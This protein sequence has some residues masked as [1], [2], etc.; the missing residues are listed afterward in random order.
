M[1]TLARICVQRP[2]FATVLSLTLLVVGAAGYVG[3]GVDRFP[4]VDFPF[5]VVSTTYPGASPAE[6]ETEVTDPI[7]EQVNT[8]GGIEALTSNSA[9][10]ISIVSVQFDLSKNV[11]VAAEEVRAKVALAKADLPP[12]VK[13]PVV[14]KIDIGATPVI[15]F[16]VSA[17]RPV[18][19][20]YEYVDKHVR[21]RIESVSG[22]GEVQIIGG[23]KRQ[24][25]VVVDPYRLRA[26]K[27]TVADITKALTT[28]NTMVPGG[29]VEQGDNELSLR[30][31]GRLP[32]VGQFNE[33][34]ISSL[35]NREIYLRDVAKTED[36]EARAVSLASIG[37]RDAVVLQVIKQTGANAVEVIDN[38]RDRMKLIEQALPRGYK[39]DVVRDQSTY[40]RA[41]LNA[42]REH[43]VMGAILAALVVLAFLGNLRSTIIAA[44]AIPTSV[45]TTFALMKY[46][47]FTQNNVTLLALTLSVG[48]VID[49]AIVVLENVYRVIEEHGLNPVEGAIRATKEIG[50]AVVAIT[51]SLVAVFLPVA[52]MS[53]IVG[54]FLNSFGITM[55]CAIGVSMFISFSLTPMLCSRWLQGGT[56]AKGHHEAESKSG[57]FRAVD[58]FYTRML[59]WSL[60]HRFLVVLGCVLLIFA[61]KFIGG[62]AKKSFLPDDDEAQFQVQVRAQEGTSLEGT[63][64]IAEE[65]AG[66]IRK[67]PEVKL[68]LVTVGDDRQ[69]TANRAGIFVRMNEVEERQSRQ[70]TQYTNMDT[71]R[72]TILPKYDGRGLRLSVQKAGGFG[73]GSNAAIQLAVYGPDLDKLTKASDDA[74]RKCRSIAGVADVDSTL[75]TGKPELQAQVDRKRAA[76]L[77]VNVADTARALRVAVGGDDKISQFD[78]GGEQYEVHVRLGPEYRRDAE[79]IYLLDV[80]NSLDG[81]GGQT[82][83]DQVV[84]FKRSSAPSVINRYNRQRQF[85]LNVNILPGTNQQ[86]I[87]QQVTEVLTGLNL[88]PEY[89]VEPT[90]QA[91]EFGRMIKSFL[92]AFMLSALFMYLVI[93]AQFESFVHAM[94]IMLTLPLTLP[95]AMLSIVL[96]NDSLNL[97]SMLGMLVLLGVVKKN[98]ILQV[99]RANQL[100]E[101]GLSLHDATVQAS[102]DRL[103]PI[104]MTT[105]AFVAGM[106]PLVLSRGTGAATNRSTGSVIVWG[107]ILSLL[108]TLLAAPVFYYSFDTF[109]N[110][111]FCK[112]LRRLVFRKGR[113]A[114]EHPTTDDRSEQV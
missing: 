24:V 8:I 84:K 85:Q 111:T 100:R 58:L 46:L 107:Q 7:E 89:R 101:E 60:H 86:Q 82:S 42:V 47:G 92:T 76:S 94:V 88:G 97:F 22:V 109:A 52:F 74:M 23:R 95:F 12:D 37:G 105:V 43:L 38:V 13:E 53:G 93:A 40:I 96:S 54:R 16:A 71:V 26:H 56:E 102:R 39:V 55:A 91:R 30:T 15:S 48:I 66:E 108:L 51:L 14:L 81:K 44:L 104:L 64:K 33:I 106:I 63:R 19:E 70:V 68:S 11:D 57:W 10:G 99:D 73:G 31:I 69:Q 36:G 77:G 34:P 4:N 65:I 29:V 110:S 45:I 78:E 80:P 98:A 17:D 87:T 20:I 103:R 41:S 21:R 49:D 72:R 1:H 27:V 75:V 2:V 35:G 114:A 112:G 59:E 32:K 3:L 18:R 90:G 50:L 9:D 28:Q 6:V 67:L 113:Q 25:N 61:T 83:L 79:G 62:A 5:V